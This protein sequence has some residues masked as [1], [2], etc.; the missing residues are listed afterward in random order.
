MINKLFACAGMVVLSL[1]LVGCTSGGSSEPSKAEDAQMRKAV[2]GEGVGPM[3]EE[4]RKQMEAS[5]KFW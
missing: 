5:L 4:T 2:K 1:F 3:P